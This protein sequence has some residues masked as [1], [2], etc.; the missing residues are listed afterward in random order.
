MQGRYRG[1][2]TTCHGGL[3]VFLIALGQDQLDSDRLLELRV[4]LQ[5]RL[6]DLDL[7]TRRADTA[8]RVF[9]AVHGPGCSKLLSLDRGAK[10]MLNQPQIVTRLQRVDWNGP[11]PLRACATSKEARWSV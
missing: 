1:G 8:E 9:G 10:M 3:P 5:Q 6:E 11:V 7:R 4:L 2:V